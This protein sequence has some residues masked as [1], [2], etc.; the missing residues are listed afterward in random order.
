MFEGEKVPTKI[1][2]NINIL[3]S[4]NSD[5]TETINDSDTSETTQVFC[6]SSTSI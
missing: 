1:Y 2:I 3:N 6:S 4:N 5:D